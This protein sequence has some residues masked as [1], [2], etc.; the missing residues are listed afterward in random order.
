MPATRQ[1]LPSRQA[2]IPPKAPRK[3]RSSGAVRSTP[4]PHRRRTGPIPVEKKKPHP[5]P[6][7]PNKFMCYRSAVIGKMGILYPGTSQRGLSRIIGVS[8]HQMTKAEQEPFKQEAERRKAA[9]LEVLARH[10]SPIPPYSDE[11][12]ETT[13]ER[14]HYRGDRE[15]R[16]DWDLGT[17][18]VTLILSPTDRMSRWRAKTKRERLP[19]SLSF[20][21]RDERILSLH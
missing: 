15:T 18:Q 1:P 17:V 10:S 14:C 6:R 12:T 2:L 7:T 11:P 19:C 4:S 8:W 20:R 21:W 5:P 3:R 13:M 9:Q 16:R